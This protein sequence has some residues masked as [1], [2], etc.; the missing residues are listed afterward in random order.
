MSTTP[1][2]RLEVLGTPAPKG[3]MRAFMT[4]GA[5]PRAVI[6]TGGSK[7]NQQKLR[8]WD[9]SVRLAAAEV[10]QGRAAPVFVE[11]PINV[12]ILFRL[13]R[14]AGHWGTRGL[15]PGAPTYPIVKPDGDKLTRA[16][17]DSMKGTIYDDDARVVRKVV[18]KIYADPGCEGAT[19]EVSQ[20]PDPRRNP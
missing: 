3:S 6:A 16:T 8:S 4:R 7:V 14:P 11:V 19:I 10:T 2:I 13:A 12:Q 18:E 20:V 17:L 15:K 9:Q 5:N 1:V